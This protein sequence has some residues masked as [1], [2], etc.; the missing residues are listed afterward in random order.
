MQRIARHWT[1][2]GDQDIVYYIPWHCFAYFSNDALWCTFHLFAHVLVSILITSG[3]DFSGCWLCLLCCDRPYPTSTIYFPQWHKLCIANMAFCGCL[4]PALNYISMMCYL[5]S[6]ATW[7]IQLHD[8]QRPALIKTGKLKNSNKTHLEGSNH[9]VVLCAHVISRKMQD[10]NPIS[11]CACSVTTLGKFRCIC[12][13]YFCLKR[14]LPK[15]I[16]KSMLCFQ[17]YILMIHECVNAHVPRP[18]NV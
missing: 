18:L 15:A 11:S 13:F 3:K 12:D 2:H 6:T 17:T 1:K 4:L 5:C 14:P 10:T 8:W 16:W 7:T 9:C